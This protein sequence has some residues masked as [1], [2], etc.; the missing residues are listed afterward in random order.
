[1]PNGIGI[2]CVTI[3]SPLLPH[4]CYC[5]VEGPSHRNVIKVDERQDDQYQDYQ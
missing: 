5:Y 3:P 2:G 4:R 1:M